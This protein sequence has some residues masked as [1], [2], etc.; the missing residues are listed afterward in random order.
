[1]RR[2][3]LALFVLTLLGAGALTAVHAE[4][5]ERSPYAMPRTHVVSIQDTTSDR[6][7]ELY[8]KLPE[9]Y[10]EETDKKYPVIYTTDAAWHMDMLSGATE[11][12]MPDAILV[13]ISWQKDLDP[14]K[15]FASRFRDY[16]VTEYSNP[17]TQATHQ[18]G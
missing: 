6:P 8:V 2:A 10:A 5:G 3:T 17:E 9:G 1:M 7:Y 18:G 4:A 11:Y 16:T 14:D 12:L 15:A 13:G